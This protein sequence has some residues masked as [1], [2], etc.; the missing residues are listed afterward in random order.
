MLKL[1]SSLNDIDLV[2]TSFQ[3]Y[4]R[5]MAPLVVDYRRCERLGFCKAGKK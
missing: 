1:K 3:R 4:R 2:V 5:I